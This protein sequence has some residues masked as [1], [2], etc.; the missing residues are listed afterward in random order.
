MK[1]GTTQRANLSA[2][3]PTL[4]TTLSFHPHWIQ[5]EHWRSI[6]HPLPAYREQTIVIITSSLNTEGMVKI[7]HP[8]SPSLE[9]TNDNIPHRY[10]LTEYRGKVKIHFPSSASLEGTNDVSQS[11]NIN[12]KEIQGSIV[13]F[14][15]KCFKFNIFS[16]DKMEMH[17]DHNLSLSTPKGK[18][19]SNCREKESPNL[20]WSNLFQVKEYYCKL[21]CKY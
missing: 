3:V 16:K 10:I 4:S 8:S 5:R 21:A 12:N 7:H 19:V 11:C 20:A 1:H 15:M 6:T 14:V 17:M 13:K 18:H 2:I 9:G